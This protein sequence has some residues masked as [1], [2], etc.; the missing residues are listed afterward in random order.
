M[1]ELRVELT[2]EEMVACLAEGLQSAVSYCQVGATARRGTGP[3]ILRV[4]PPVLPAGGLASLAVLVDP[5]P[6]P[7]QALAE[8][9]RLMVG[10]SGREVRAETSW[11]PV[12]GYP[13][14]LLRA[15]VSLG[16]TSCLTVRGT[17]LGV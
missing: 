4:E 17:L 1:Q 14:P 15:E 12:Q 6:V 16:D 11:A 5:G 9:W 2:E 7:P 8:S 13:A 10:A 3:T